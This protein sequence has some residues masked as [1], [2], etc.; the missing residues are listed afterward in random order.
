M[1]AVL[2][3]E[4]ACPLVRPASL[5]PPSIQ[6]LRRGR[7]RRLPAVE[8]DMQEAERWLTRQRWLCPGAALLGNV[9][10][11]SRRHLVVKIGIAPGEML[12]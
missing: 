7:M 10:S 12:I 11:C 6:H 2:R 4:P 3:R 5:L 9:L 1:G 8:E